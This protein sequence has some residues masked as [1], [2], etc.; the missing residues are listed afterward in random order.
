MTKDE[1]K[2]IWQSF[3]RFK[4][5]Y[6]RATFA[7]F[8]AEDDS[9]GRPNKKRAE[10]IK[11]E[12]FQLLNPS[13]AKPKQEAAKADFQALTERI[14]THK[15]IDG[16]RPL[17]NNRPVVAEKDDI[18][19]GAFH[20]WLGKSPDSPVTN[21]DIEKG[22]NA[23]SARVRKMAQFAKNMREAIRAQLRL[24]IA[25]RFYIVSD[26]GAVLESNDGRGFESIEEAK[27]WFGQQTAIVGR[28]GIGLGEASRFGQT[29]LAG[30]DLLSEA[31]D[32]DLS[33]FASDKTE[34]L[35]ALLQ[36]HGV[37]YEVQGSKLHLHNSED[38]HF[39]VDAMADIEAGHTPTATEA[40]KG[41][42]EVAY[43]DNNGKMKRKAFKTDAAR[44]QWIEKQGD[45]IQ[46][47]SYL[48]PEP[49]S[50]ATEAKQYPTGTEAVKGEY[51]VAYVDNNGKIKRKPFMKP[52][53]ER[54]QGEG[55]NDGVTPRI[56]RNKGF[57]KVEGR[58]P[59]DPDYVWFHGFEPKSDEFDAPTVTGYFGKDET[60]NGFQL[61]YFQDEE[62]PFYLSI[63]SDDGEG[64]YEEGGHYDFDTFAKAIS[65]IQKMDGHIDP[66]DMRAFAAH[67]K[68]MGVTLE[69]TALESFND[70]DGTWD[71]IEAGRWLQ[72][73]GDAASYY[74][75][76]GKYFGVGGDLGDEPIEI[77]RDDL[78][79]MVDNPDDPYGFGIDDSPGEQPGVDYKLESGEL[80]RVKFNSIDEFVEYIASR[81]PDA[82]FDID[83]R[84]NHRSAFASVYDG[85]IG[86]VAY[87][88]F[89][90][91]AMYYPDSD[92]QE[93]D[94]LY[95]EHP[96]YQTESGSKKNVTEAV[97]LTQVSDEDMFDE[98]VRRWALDMSGEEGRP[99]NPE[100]LARGLEELRDLGRDDPELWDGLKDHAVDA[101]ERLLKRHQAD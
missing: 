96:D 66:K 31:T 23:K 92:E 61:A 77:S 83:S 58:R 65:Q 14:Q 98:I 88:E 36:Q 7:S 73:R 46:V 50:S 53:A 43:V 62:N 34:P 15:G 93:P 75:R 39:V 25:E 90:K 84:R 71:D 47:D 49:R 76:D 81:W 32:I 85:T 5:R 6:P 29:V 78:K 68:G 12:I 30:S 54:A 59:K 44:A 60:D 10:E 56:L 18:K 20:K 52:D 45:D 101:L 4:L 38:A 94:P 40:S 57:K 22:L 70:P 11:N 35:K 74:K 67:L 42:Y 63:L 51:E 1:A 8:A 95:P 55:S 19:K 33:G 48:D 79:A 27:K 72:H 16:H 89:S 99:D 80:P 86:E 9:L 82:E 41:E 97:D 91:T 26:K 17:S 87:D 24:P 100:A 28:L 2:A 69:S 64:D 37:E 13:Q 3:Q 21:A